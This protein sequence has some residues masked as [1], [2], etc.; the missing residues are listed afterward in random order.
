MAHLSQNHA[1]DP[2]FAASSNGFGE[3]N[4]SSTCHYH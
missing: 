3:S 1:M 2:S 4:S